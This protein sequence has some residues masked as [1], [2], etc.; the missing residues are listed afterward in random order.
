[1]TARPARVTAFSSARGRRQR[2]R[3]FTLLELLIAVTLMSVL[4]LSGARRLWGHDPVDRLPDGPSAM[5]G[6]WLLP[7][8]LALIGL[9]GAALLGA[10]AW[11]TWGDLTPIDL[12]A[13]YWSGIAVAALAAAAC[14]AAF[15]RALAGADLAAPGWLP[16]ILPR[17]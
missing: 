3:G 14:V 1:M 10:V 6:R 9:A 2:E 4:A 15:Q 17:D 13:A 7:A 11:R 12:T 16:G 5:P 8:L